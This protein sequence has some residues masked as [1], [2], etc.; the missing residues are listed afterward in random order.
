MHEG[1]QFII[2]SL[3]WI[4]LGLYLPLKERSIKDP[5][6]RRKFLNKN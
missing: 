1:T 5:E 3:L 4:G 6:G 2:I